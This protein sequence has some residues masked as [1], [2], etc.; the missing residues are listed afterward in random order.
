MS[1]LELLSAAD[2]C[3]VSGGDVTIIRTKGSFSFHARNHG[4]VNV[5]QRTKRSSI[6]YGRQGQM[7]L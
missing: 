3:D 2:I 4:H 6:L 5:E 1:V 7:E